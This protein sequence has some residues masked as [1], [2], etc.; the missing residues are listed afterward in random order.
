MRALRCRTV[1]HAPREGCGGAAPSARVSK[2][3][4][5]VAGVADRLGRRLRGRCIGPAEVH[6][7]R[8]RFPVACQRLCRLAPSAIE[9]CHN[10]A[11]AI[12]V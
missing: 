2:H 5:D 3:H 6:C 12:E 11:I 7:Q 9:Q 10:W 8:W 4:I 1:S